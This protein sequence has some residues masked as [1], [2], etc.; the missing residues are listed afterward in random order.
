[1]EPA[2]R[3]Q[4]LDNLEQRL[5]DDGCLFLGTDEMLDGDSLAFRPVAGRPGLFVKAPGALRR[6]A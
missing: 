3:G 4:T 6:A 5:I 2:R 1:M